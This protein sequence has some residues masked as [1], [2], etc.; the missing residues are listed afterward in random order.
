MRYPTLLFLGFLTTGAA[1]PAIAANIS[2]TA[3]KIELGH[4]LFYDADLSRD[5]SMS[6]ATCH[7]QRH[8]FSDANPTHPGVTDEDGIRNV[9]PLA[10]VGQFHTLTWINQHVT[11]LEDQFFIPLSGHHPVEMGMT[12]MPEL[13]RRLFA[14]PCYRVLFS[15]A[16][17]EKN[18]PID[19]RSVAQ[20]MSAFEQELISDK[21]PWDLRLSGATRSQ[22]NGK[23]IFFGKGK[24]SSCHQPPL[25][26][27]Q[28]FHALSTSYSEPIRTPSLRNVEVTAPYL[29]DGSAPTLRKAIL[30]HPK[31]NLL[32]QKELIELMAFLKLL[33][34]H[35]FLSDAS[36][37]LP[38]EECPISTQ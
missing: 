33:T 15:K 31:S 14:N 24:C 36:L 22:T 1:F 6:C 10:N 11:T 38:S 13:A 7:E 37:G 16:F 17:P 3:A 32:S 4:R 8:A 2:P 20:A 27:D 9:P 19:A 23:K 35:N 34:D 28:E 29:H 18:I 21:S 5:G 30:A 25:F 26:T 12:D